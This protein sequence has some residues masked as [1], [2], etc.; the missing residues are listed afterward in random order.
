MKKFNYNFKKRY[1][2]NAQHRPSKLAIAEVDSMSGGQDIL[3]HNVENETDHTVFSP[4]DDGEKDD[5]DDENDF[6]DADGS[7]DKTW[8]K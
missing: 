2:I 8:C 6:G 5:D 3:Y 7:D 1:N 4:G